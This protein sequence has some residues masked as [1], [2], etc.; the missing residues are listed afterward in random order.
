MEVAPTSDDA[1]WKD[2]A[3]Q[4]G[5]LP[6]ETATSQKKRNANAISRE[7]AIYYE[8]YRDYSL[9]HKEI[10]K[11]QKIGI[12]SSRPFWEYRQA[13]VEKLAYR[14][15]FNPDLVE[16]L[17]SLSMPARLILT[18]IF[19][20]S[21]S[22]HPTTKKICSIMARA[23]RGTP[24]DKVATLRE[25]KKNSEVKLD[26]LS[27]FGCNIP[28]NNIELFPTPLKEFRIFYGTHMATWGSYLIIS[29]GFGDIGAH[30]DPDDRYTFVTCYDTVTREGLWQIDV[31][32]LNKLHSTTRGVFVSYSDVPF[33]NSRIIFS[34]LNPE[35]GEMMRTIELPHRISRL[36][37]QISPSGICY[38]QTEIGK[39]LYIVGFDLAGNSN[40]PL[41]EY[42][43]SER[44]DFSLLGEYLYLKKRKLLISPKGE[45]INLPQHKQLKYDSGIF[46]VLTKAAKGQ[47]SIAA[48]SIEEFANGKIPENK[49]YSFDSEHAELKEVRN[50]CVYFYL[51]YKER[52]RI[53]RFIDMQNRANTFDVETS[54][55]Y[56]IHYGNQA[57]WWLK[58]GNTL[59]KYTQQGTETAARFSKGFAV[60]CFPIYDE[61]TGT[62]YA[63]TDRHDVTDVELVT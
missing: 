35:T 7:S 49:I 3:V 30:Q 29:N 23:F 22:C 5:L 41:H 37:F 9:L 61:K 46:Y 21:D 60:S 17:Q 15:G 55:D 19:T 31:P 42:P 47:Y 32:L 14:D 8:L 10:I 18:R 6:Q 52:K 54:Y 12:D 63:R 56:P 50:G 53:H 40:I 24:R 4:E 59:I 13:L 25:L 33:G 38:Y 43:I 36:F 11:L 34:E 57:M 27:L 2:L 20:R 58:E 28:R 48:C 62:I 44:E 26:Y 39:K 45:W 51:Y 16:L 1:F